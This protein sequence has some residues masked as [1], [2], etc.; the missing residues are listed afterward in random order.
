MKFLIKANELSSLLTV[1][2]TVFVDARGGADAY[3][4]FSNGHLEGAL[5]VDLE[6]D[7]SEKGG[8]AKDGGRHPLPSIENFGRL[9]G[10]LGIMPSTTVVIYD[11]KRGANAAARMWWMLR[12]VGHDRLFVVDGGLEAIVA[13]GLPISTEAWTLLTDYPPY[14]VLHWELPTV[15]LEEVKNA[16]EIDAALIVD[17]RENY[18]F[19]GESEPIDL[20]A[21]HIPSAQNI[22]YTENLTAD[23]VFADRDVLKEKYE[24]LLAGHEMKEVIVHC[25]SGVTACHT[26]LALEELGLSGASLYVGSWS[27]W[28]RNGLP[29][30]TAE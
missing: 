25:G 17:V 29:I 6:T 24:R 28:S 21:G 5:F 26:L 16:V 20:V 1:G 11:D 12:A 3:D 18:R 13:A 7:L 10:N 19:N 9:L 15:G 14:P 22:P 8:D 23:G 30:Q 2:D 4:R 27:E